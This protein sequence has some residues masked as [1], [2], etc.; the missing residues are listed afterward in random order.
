MKKIIVFIS[1]FMSVSCVNKTNHIK[2]C[3]DR[4]MNSSLVNEILDRYFS[5]KELIDSKWFTMGIDEKNNSLKIVIS[6]L[7]QKGD[8][9]TRS[10]TSYI[11][12]DDKIIF[13]KCPLNYLL[14]I[15]NGSLT[16]IKYKEVISRIP[17][18]VDLK[19]KKYPIWVILIKNENYKINSY[20]HIPNLEPS[21]RFIPP[22]IPKSDNDK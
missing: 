8:S 11:T 21:I 13:V 3:D 9:L 15:D 1:L 14:P 12:Y 4:L 19:N 22:V 7:I 6:P 10:P 2:V 16:I 5:Q 20:I 17:K 18:Y